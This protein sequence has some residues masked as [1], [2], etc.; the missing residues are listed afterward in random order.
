MIGAS[1]RKSRLPSTQARG[2]PNSPP[3]L[4]TTTNRLETTDVET[5]MEVDEEEEVTEESL[6]PIAAGLSTRD[7]RFLLD[8]VRRVTAQH[9]VENTAAA[10]DPKAVEYE[11][12]CNYQYAGSHVSSRYTVTTEKVFDFLFYQAFRDKYGRGGKKRGTGYHGFDPVDYTKVTTAYAA[13]MLEARRN[14][15]TFDIPDP[16][17]PVGYDLVHTY[18]AVLFNIWCEQAAEGANSTTWELI[19][20][21]RVKQLI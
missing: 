2:A 8:V 18:K 20:T 15:T 12:F 19:Y 14:P 9:R 6:P 21:A 3:T 11:Q 10:Y 7:R 1:I 16:K 4:G 13:H 5:V 17:D